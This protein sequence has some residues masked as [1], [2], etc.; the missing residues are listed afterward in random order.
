MS[1]WSHV[2][3]IISYLLGVLPDGPPMS[4]R[5]FDVKIKLPGIGPQVEASMFP[6]TDRATQFGLFL[7]HSHIRVELEPESR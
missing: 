3:K 2:G 6:F 5:P 4:Y 7:T 1:N